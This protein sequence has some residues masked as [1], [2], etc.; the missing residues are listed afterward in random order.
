MEGYQGIRAKLY[1][2]L[3]S[4]RQPDDIEFYKEEALQTGDSVLELGCGTGRVLIPLAES[5]LQV[6]GLEPYS[7]MFEIAKQNISRLKN[8]DQERIQVIEG[9]MRDFS[10]GRQFSTILIPYRAFH[11]VLTPENQRKT[12]LCIHKHLD[13]NGILI[14]H[15]G[16]PKLDALVSASTGNTGITKL[17]EFIHPETGNRVILWGNRRCNLETQ[18]SEW[19]YTYEE[20][21]EYGVT[22]SRIHNTDTTRHVFKNE[23]QYLLEL[24]GYNIKA[25]YGNFH[26]DS[27]RYGREQVWLV[28]KNKKKKDK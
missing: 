25:L 18:I 28:Q 15:N 13:D 1:D 23:M 5:G 6:V 22:I 27:Y 12:L 9:D 11:H 17:S 14:I 10:L 26:R 2:A 8:E 7:P 20:L 16:D 24:C 19:H 4:L 3:A 21:D